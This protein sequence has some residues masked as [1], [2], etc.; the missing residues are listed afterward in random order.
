M[1]RNYVTSEQLVKFYPKIIQYRA[2]RGADVPYDF[3][4]DIQNAFEE[5]SS[6]LRNRD[7]DLGRI[8]TPL[9]LKT[10]KEP[11]EAWT[12]TSSTTGDAFSAHNENRFIVEVSSITDSCSLQ[13]E[14]SN[15]SS[16]WKLIASLEISQ[17]GT[18]AKSFSERWKYY[19]YK[20]FIETS[21][22]FSAY[23]IDAQCDFLIMWKSAMNV[24]LPSIG[25]GDTT[26][27]LYDELKS[28][29]MDSLTGLKLDYDLDDSGSINDNESNIIKPRRRAA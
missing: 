12:E 15:D 4:D 28:L 11:Y 1:F 10:S 20:S 27:I 29:Y 2:D 13:L 24:L 18:A 16:T 25:S 22:T 21:A 6:E 14:G 5:V 23:I 9:M 8:Y 17:T 19:R 3:T 7:Y 26:K